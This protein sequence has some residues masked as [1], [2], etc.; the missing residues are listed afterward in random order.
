MD[1]VN[2]N[3]E[4]KLEKTFTLLDDFTPPTYDEWKEKVLA[5]LKGKPFEKLQTKIIEGITLQPIYTK[6]DLQKLEAKDQFPGF[7][8]NIRGSKVSGYLKDSW[9]VSQNISYGDPAEFNTALK[10]DLSKGQTAIYMSLDKAAM[11]GLDADYAKTEDV[12]RNGVSISG[13]NSF[14]RAMDGINIQ[15]YPL[16]IQCGF[17]SVPMLSI[18]NAYCKQERIDIA[19]IN[20]AAEADPITF[21]ASESKLPVS[22]NFT[23]EKMSAALSWTKSNA[24]DIKTINASGLLYNNSGANAVQELSYI[25]ASANEYIKKML[26]YGFTIDEIIKSLKV[27]VG[28]GSSFFTEISKLRALKILWKNLVKPY[29]AKEESEKVYIHGVTSGFNKTLFD[30]HINILRVTTEAFSAIMGGIDS[31]HTSPF[32]EPFSISND[33]SRRI[34]RNT[35]IILNEEAHFSTPIDPA[36]GS[37]FVESL[38]NELAKSA[39]KNFQEI[40]KNGGMIE[41]LKSGIIQ[42]QIRSTVDERNKLISKRKAVIVGTNMYANPTETPIETKP[43]DH[44]S[45]QKKRAEFLQKFRTSGEL[46]KNHSILDKLNTLTEKEGSEIIDISSQAILEGATLGEITH[47]HRAGTSKSIAVEKIVPHRAAEPFEKLRLKVREME[48]NSGSRPKVFLATIG[49]IK[50]Y[51]ARADFSRGFFE[52]AGFEVVYPSGLTEVEN[53]V[54]ETI[55]SNSKIAVI[56]STDDKYQ[57]IVPTYVKL[58]RE[59]NPDIIIVLAGYPKDMVDEYKQNGV[60]EFIYL[61]A[62]AYSILNKIINA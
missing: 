2:D 48:I 11:L 14:S 28:I 61:G 44:A 20:G 39:W 3:S 13:L 5:D 36:G 34:A 38:T 23:F 9:L 43:F 52:I 22:L 49:S 24:P 35:Q 8:N 25:L 15:K 54:A 33:F 50:E 62:D 19:N 27:T 21:L 46:K 1:S 4:I 42:D 12:G 40:E 32:D 7:V 45:L 60:D 6:N 53:A 30:P 51:K 16:F 58:L 59:K 26:E 17:S 31:L 10:N 47:S 29:N 37:Y 41:S 56:C 55:K 57:E 18:L